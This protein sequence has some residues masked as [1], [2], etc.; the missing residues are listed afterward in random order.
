EVDPAVQFGATIRATDAVDAVESLGWRSVVYG[1]PAARATGEN[2]LRD[3]VEDV[4]AGVDETPR[5]LV[6]E[7]EHSVAVLAT[8]HDRLAERLLALADAI[9]SGD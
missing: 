3:A 6:G 4:I 9:E 2:Q 5:V 1:P 8:E 7:R